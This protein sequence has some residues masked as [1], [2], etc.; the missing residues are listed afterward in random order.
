[1]IKTKL[2]KF[3]WKNK[4]DKIIREG[5]YQ[6]RDKG[7]IRMIDVG[8]MIKAPSRLASIPRLCAPGRKNW[9]TVPDYYLG[10]YGGFL[11]TTRN[12]L[13]VHHETHDYR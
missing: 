3:L 6:D 2:F 1:M 8:T 4:K 9:A 11:T 10:G 12:I 7:G 5:L 13:T